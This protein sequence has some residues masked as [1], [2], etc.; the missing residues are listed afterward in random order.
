MSSATSPI[1]AVLFDFGLVLSGPPD[2]AAWSRLKAVFDVDDKALNTAYWRHRHD[3]DRGDLNAPSYW[4]AIANDLGKEIDVD[5]LRLLVEADTDLW[6]FENEPMVAWAKSLPARG[7]KRGILSNIGDAMEQGV[8]ERC[9][10]L[11]DFD[12]HTF[13]HRLL[14]AKP[15]AAIYLYAAAGLGLPPEEILFIDDREENVAAARALGMKAIHYTD[16]TAFLA[17]LHDLGLS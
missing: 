8:L 12:H 16:H 10:W 11:A 14:M 7:L 2:P 4:G 17:E 6:T 15:E 9:A 3:Y 5:K 13:S 1:R